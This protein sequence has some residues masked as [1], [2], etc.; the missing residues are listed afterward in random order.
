MLTGHEP[1]DRLAL[2]EA[3]DEGK[4][5]NDVMYEGNRVWSFNEVVQEYKRLRKLGTLES[6]SNSFYV[7]LTN[8]CGSIAHYNKQ[9]W[10]EEYHNSIDSLHDFFRC[11]EFG[12]DIASYQPSRFTDR[13]KITSYLLQCA[14]EHGE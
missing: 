2:Q 1:D 10:V 13:K 3:I 5:K 12:V 14:D 8:C 11:N 9:G 4:I 6:M 7:F